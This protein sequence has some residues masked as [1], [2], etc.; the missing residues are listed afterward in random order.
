[1]AELV[2]INRDNAM[3]LDK[4]SQNLKKHLFYDGEQQGAQLS[5]SIT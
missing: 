5:E 1:M 3:E 4:I 2:K